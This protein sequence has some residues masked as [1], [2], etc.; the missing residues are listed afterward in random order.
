M[1][2]RK[3]LV[4][5]LVA[6]AALSLAACGGDKEDSKP[7]PTPTPS[8]VIPSPTEPTPTPTETPSD[9]TPTPSETP[10]EKVGAYFVNGD[11][12]TYVEAVDDLV[13]APADP[14][15]TVYKTFAGWYASEEA[16]KSLDETQKFNPSAPVV[17]DVYYYAGWAGKMEEVTISCDGAQFGTLPNADA[18]TTYEY[19]NFNFGTVKGQQQKYGATV[20]KSGSSVTI[21]V[22][23]NATL[24]M[25]LCSGSSNAFKQYIYLASVDA[26]G[27]LIEL[28][29]PTVKAEVNNTNVP[30][31][32][33]AV[34]KEAFGDYEFELAPG[35]YI[36]STGDSAKFLGDSNGGGTHLISSISL[37][38]EKEMSPIEKIELAEDCPVYNV[39]AGREVDLSTVK[40]KASYENGRV[41]I[42]TI[43]NLDIDD[44]KVDTTKAG[45][46]PVGISYYNEIDGE[47]YNTEVNVNVF[48]IDSLDLGTYAILKDKD[49]GESRVTF[50]LQTVFLADA[51]FN[52]NYL[53]VIANGV[54]GDL[55]EEFIL[56]ASE[57]TLTKNELVAGANDITISV[58]N[59]TTTSYKVTLVTNIFGEDATE[60][61]VNV[62][63]SKDT[64]VVEGNATFKTVTEA[65]QYLKLIEAKDDVVKTINIAPGTYM[66]KI[67][68][69]LPNVR[70]VG[71]GASYDEVVLTYDALNGV[72]D[73]S[74]TQVH[75][76]DGAASVSIRSSATGFYAENIT[77][78][79]EWNTH[80]DYVASQAI[81]SNTQA[82]ACLVQADQSIFKNV[83]FSSYH[84]TLYAQVGRQYYENCYIEGRT[85]YI[86]GYNA[87]AYF[88]NCEIVSIG[89]GVDQ[90]NGG[91]VVATKGFRSASN[92]DSVKYGY[93][94]DG[95]NFRGD[96]NVKDG[97]VSIARGWG[98]K[99]TIMVMNS[100]LSKA[101]SKTAFGDTSVANTNNRYTSMNAGPV[102][103]LLFEYNNT[104]DGAITE[105]LANTCTVLTDAA[106]AAVYQD[107]FTVFN[108]SNGQ[109]VWS[110]TWNPVAEKDSIVNVVDADGNVLYTYNGY[111]GQ[112]ITDKKLKEIEAVLVVPSGKKFV[113]FFADAAGATAYDTT[114]ALTAEVTIYA[115][116]ED[117]GTIVTLSYD[118]FAETNESF[119]I[120]QAT[121]GSTK[122]ESATEGAANGTG[123]S[124]AKL[125]NPAD[126]IETVEFAAAKSA[127]VEMLAG[128]SSTGNTQIFKIEAID[129]TGA[130][131]ATVYSAPSCSGKV[132]G[133]MVD[134]EGNK[135]VEIASDAA[136]VKVR[137]SATGD[138]ATVG[139]Q[140]CAG[141][142]F[143]VAT[144]NVSYS[145]EPTVL[146]YDGFA[147]TNESFVI[148]QAT[149]GSTK[150]ESATEGA[151]NGTGTSLAK[152]VNP[153]DYIE[154]VEFAAAKSAKVEMLAGTSSTGNTQI[155]K[156]E[157][158]DATGAVVATVYSAPSC[159][160]K[161]LGYIV[162]ADGNKYV[163]IS[164]DVEFVKI[165]VSATGDK[166]TVGDQ[167]CAGKNFCVATLKVTI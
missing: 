146:E 23:E 84:D 153:A 21:T 61:V 4:G 34:P 14:V 54:C 161:V 74:G 140:G 89:A 6:G 94:F 129:A 24:K 157:A 126:Y 70:L 122:W 57:Y 144:L 148:S 52:N 119:V 90:G 155:F 78:Q 162:D 151:A 27:N 64:A 166:A 143:C 69:Q 86:F 128:T 9:V 3:L 81:T 118:G 15:G 150:W 77:I 102:A 76:T 37:T 154:T 110:E 125:V 40:V 87:T 20:L 115:V 117:A 56:D 88:K 83:K 91:Y 28:V 96:E 145:V 141:K 104:G 1:K 159:S 59:G 25:T 133:Y 33:I 121:A 111:V 134:A 139:D 66:E 31:Q 95:C 123:T 73:P 63:G 22:E 49:L 82:T 124:L 48:E 72:M 85:D 127:K 65:L 131:V 32:G 51:D 167:S 36:L 10:A 147:E 109:V 112:T 58:A 120:S 2:K 105:S 16:A 97:S 17:E 53:T 55:T 100:T 156:I 5:L 75:S 45:V 46:Y 30:T 101:F 116:F 137:V 106:A 135:Y 136:F 68:V 152:L 18:T 113:G 13:T 19:K 71:T 11:E 38:S 164:S 163:E 8:D 7:T 165:R 138:K 114:A 103:D 160:G 130:V 93:V 12:V 149:A 79:N 158:I 98:D 107:L 50:N 67:E 47:S 80:A 62:D 35:T 26:S 142:N 108:Y 29:Q 99:M 132:L 60:Y 44:S 92:T 39:L 41:E 43:E 42:L